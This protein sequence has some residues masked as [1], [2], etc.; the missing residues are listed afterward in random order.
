MMDRRLCLALFCI[1][2]GI[3]LLFYVDQPYEADGQAL[4]SVSASLVRH[5]S[6][7]MNTIAYSDWILP[8]SAGMGRTGIDGATYSK[9]G[10]SPSLALTPLVLLSELAPWLSTQATAMFFNPLITAFTGVMLYRLTRKQNFSE[11]TAFITALLFGIAT[12]AFVYTKTLFGEPFAALLLIFIAYHLVEYWRTLKIKDVLIIGLCVG[13]LIGVN[14]VYVLYAPL[15]GI[16]LL[17]RLFATDR[18]LTRAKIRSLIG[19]SAPILIALFLLGLFNIARFGSLTEAGYRFSEGEGFIHPLT[20]GLYGLFLSPYRGIF[21]YSPLLLLTIPATVMLIRQ[22]EQR[23]FTVI[24]LLLIAAQALMFAGWW[25]WHGG[26]VWGA[27]FL[28]PI[29][30]LITLLLAPLIESAAKRPLLALCVGCFAV[31]SIGVQLLGALYSYI[32]H[33][34]YLVENFYTGDFYAPVTYLDRAVFTDAAL[35]PILGHL[36]LLLIG[37]QVEPVA[38]AEM[39]AAHILISG[40]LVLVG[41]I[42][43]K[44]WIKHGVMIA[45]L[46]TLV[47]INLIGAQ[48][49][50]SPSVQQIRA[51]ETAL[52]PPAALLAATTSYD[53]RLID[54][55]GRNGVTVINAP[56]PPDDERANHLFDYAKANT[57]QLWFLSWHP[58]ADP[59]N[60]I[61]RDLWQTAAFAYERQIDGHRALLF[62]VEHSAEHNQIGGQT[63]GDIQ[64]SSYGIERIQDALYLS[65]AW[66]VETPLTQ[67]YAW[68]VHIL[69]A[70]GNIIAQQDRQPLGGYFP[71]STWDINTQVIDRLYF[72][73]DRVNFEG[74]TVRIGWVDGATGT[75]LTALDANGNA[76]PDDFMTLAISN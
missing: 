17:W 7:D 26:V 25:S 20:T 14:N 39:N 61:E 31:L 32:P 1:L 29:I 21:W 67:D 34:A 64:L 38:L 75:R 69:D 52:Q 16:I 53:A 9:K 68:F 42:L 13:I 5:G 33:H 49:S 76:L 37:Y 65:L 57:N 55:E 24:I 66:S 54:I 73:L 15:I 72:P 4:L 43:L 30:P 11:R 28:I 12:I 36:I 10:I 60:W 35:S 8:P 62:D 27:R 41:F 22:S 2:L 50:Q 3:Y 70:N 74:L 71:T 47:A 40:G 58:P 48:R 6:A 44:G 59:Q 63:F 51:L 19:Y 18:Q 23:A 56:T 45:A 46:S